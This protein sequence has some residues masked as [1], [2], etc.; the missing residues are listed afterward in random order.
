MAGGFDP[1][2]EAAL[3]RFPQRIPCRL[4]NNAAAHHLGVV[5]EVSATNDIQIPLRIVLRARSNAFFGHEKSF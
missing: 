3:D 4:E 2:V 1:L 5:S